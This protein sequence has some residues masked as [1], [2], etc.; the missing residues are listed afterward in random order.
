MA[1]DSMDIV[2]TPFFHY[3]MIEL[4]GN[5]ERGALT[6]IRDIAP[7]NPYSHLHEVAAKYPDIRISG[8][9][10]HVTGVFIE[11]SL[12]EIIAESYTK[13]IATALMGKQQVLA[14]VLVTSNAK[15]VTFA[16]ALFYAQQILAF[17]LMPELAKA[18]AENFLGYDK[19]S[20]GFAKLDHNEFKLSDS[21]GQNGLFS[22]SK[23]EVVSRSERT[24][25]PYPIETLELKLI[26]TDTGYGQGEFLRFF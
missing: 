25:R 18:E 12:S 11:G 20:V 7:T 2:K 16:T 10:D 21:N 23:Y 8:F 17:D 26:S 14:R 5:N 22:I 13:R 24:D 15:P 3:A 6:I 19:E 9:K 1:M 4:Q